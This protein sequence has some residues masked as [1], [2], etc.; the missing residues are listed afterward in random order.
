MRPLIGIVDSG[1]GAAQAAAVA[2]ACRFR[3]RADGSVVRLDAEPDRHGHGTAIAERILRQAPQARLL[4][5][6]VFDEDRTA[7]SAAVAAALG[8]LLD[9][10]VRIINMSIGLRED[11]DALRLACRAAV[12]RGAALVG[13]VPAMGP[14]VFPAAYPGVVRVTG[15]GRCTGDEIAFIGTSRV[16]FGASPR[17]CGASRMPAVAGASLAAAR[18]SGHLAAIVAAEPGLDAPAA[19]DM[20]AAAAVHRGPQVPRHA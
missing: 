20:L 10:G 19:L 4:V 2:A 12:D 6:Q 16:D 3:A 15:D 14:V 18:V 8:W 1:V 5:A 9:Q 17:P 13:A 11:R 7:S